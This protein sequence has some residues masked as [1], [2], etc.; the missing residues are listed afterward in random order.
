[1]LNPDLS[2]FQCMSTILLVTLPLSGYQGANA[3]G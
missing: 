3:V 2:A 1:M